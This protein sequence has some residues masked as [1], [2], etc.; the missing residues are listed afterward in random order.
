MYPSWVTS[1]NPRMTKCMPFMNAIIWSHGFS[2]HTSPDEVVVRPKNRVRKR[3]P[4][5]RR[6]H[7]KM[8]SFWDVFPTLICH[9]NMS[10]GRID[11]ESSHPGTRRSSSDQL[12]PQTHKNADHITT[13][14]W[15]SC[16]KSGATTNSPWELRFSYSGSSP[17]PAKRH[18]KMSVSHTK[19]GVD[20]ML[21]EC[22]TLGIFDL[23][24]SNPPKKAL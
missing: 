13:R 24:C 22:N 1:P 9:D 8:P 2:G 10:H 4:G 21:H 15:C 18:E 12:S 6:V 5:R 11:E 16:S 19:I 3:H 14:P 17:K 7:Y 20:R 23:E